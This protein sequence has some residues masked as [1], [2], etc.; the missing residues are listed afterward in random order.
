MTEYDRDTVIEFAVEKLNGL[1]DK[2]TGKFYPVHFKKSQLIK[3][4]GL[5]AKDTLNELS[6]KQLT[7]FINAAKADREC[8]DF[9]LAYIECDWNCEDGLPNPIAAFCVDFTLGEIQAP[10]PKKSTDTRDFIFLFL[11]EVISHKFGLEFSRNDETSKHQNFTALDAI[12]EA[13]IRV[14]N[15]KD[16][17]QFSTL[18]RL[19]SNNK[20]IAQIVEKT[21]LNSTGHKKRHRKN[22]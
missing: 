8:W 15:F 12:S 21:Y 2:D 6:D 7:Q 9:L 5:G 11:A 22:L 19:R 14:A 1:I 4:L 13:S 20:I 3:T 18:S 17:I 16:A 10:K